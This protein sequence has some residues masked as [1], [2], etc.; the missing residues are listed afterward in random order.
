MNEL[1]SVDLLTLIPPPVNNLDLPPPAIG[2]P[3][4]QT[5]CR[6]E[7]AQAS[8]DYM[9]STLNVV[10]ASGSLLKKSKLP[11]SLVVRPF[12]ALHDADESIPLVSDMC[13]ARCRRCRA[14]INPFVRFAAGDNRWGCNICGAQNEVPPNFDWDRVSQTTLDRWSRSELNYGIVDYVANNDYV[15]R[16]PQPPT[17][18][19]LLDASVGATSSG[20]L[21]A[22]SETILASIDDILSVNARARVAFILVDGALNFFMIPPPQLAS[23]NEPAVISE[24]KMLVVTDLDDPFLPTNDRL[25]VELNENRAAIEKFLTTLPEY[26]ANTCASSNAMGSGLKAAL[27]L[28]N[29]SGGKIICVN[30]ALPTVGLGKLQP[31]DDP[32][33]VGTKNEHQIYAPAGTFYKSFAVD[34]NKAQVTVDLFLA[35]NSYQDV[36]TLSNLPKFTGG[37]TFY[38]PGWN[39]EKAIGTEKLRHELR[40]HLSQEIGMEGMYRARCSSG[41]RA[42]SFSGHFFVRS[43]D[44]MTFP[45][46]TRHHAYLIELQIDEPLKKPYVVI[47]GAFLYTTYNGERRIRVMTQQL[48]VSTELADVYASADEQAIATYYAHTAADKVVANGIDGAKDYINAQVAEILKTYRSDVLNAHTGTSS[49][50]SISSNLCLLPVIL[51]ALKKCVGLR[52]QQQIRPDLRVHI[53]DLLQT[54]PVPSLMK[55]LYPDMYPLHELPEEAG[56]PDEF[57]EI[58]LPQRLNL[59]GAM[60]AT[61]GLYM[62]DNGQVIFIWVGVDVVRE[63]LLDAFGVESIEQVPSGKCEMPVVEQSELNLRIRNLINASRTR[64]DTVYYPNLY[65]VHDRSEPMLKLWISSQLIEDRSE[66]EISYH[67]YLKTIYENLNR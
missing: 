31:R 62:I 59:T 6:S 43:S 21:H 14:Y 51:Y 42:V 39:A 57:G 29:N 61:Y 10:P 30:T 63:L 12:M 36:A 17:Y 47:Q 19:F 34:C 54:L 46:L 45:T 13:I 52:K 38:Y 8:S 24:P 35:G 7:Y 11:L 23:E 15:T 50:L 20:I 49:A 3:I 33:L 64:N 66:N 56:L 28:M 32:K 55:F 60:L 48:P 16:S 1:V 67:Q 65:I 53:L 44:L 9:R 27:K 37:S 40:V 5:V 18:T 4:E 58:V 41:M 26:F 25:V 22:V 2:T